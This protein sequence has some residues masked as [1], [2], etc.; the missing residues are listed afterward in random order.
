MIMTNFKKLI[1]KPYIKYIN[2]KNTRLYNKKYEVKNILD[3]K[4]TIIKGCIRKE[5]D[6]DEA[7]LLFLS[8]KSEIVFDVGCN[9]G[10]SSLLITH[11]NSLKKLVLIEPNPLSLSMAAENLIMNNKS[12]NVK[13]IPKAAYNESGVNIKLW[14]MPGAYAG[15]SL[16]INFTEM[17]NITKS[18]FDVE[19]ITL[20]EIAETYNYFPD[21][22]KIDVEGAEFSVLEGSI[23]IAKNENTLFIVEIHSSIKLNIVENT[24]KILHWAQQNNY[25]AY[26]LCEHKKLINSEHI[27]HRGRYHILLINKQKKYPEGLNRIKQ[28]LNIEQLK[29]INK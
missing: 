12:E 1:K 2:W 26:Y 25:H 5:S 14:S 27:K 4:Y 16:D 11:S 18:Y 28:G 6:Y 21:L 9:I 22:V 8:S 17:G 10:Q 23:N 3:K 13:F 29:F 7:W 15:A 19:T 24:N 20:D